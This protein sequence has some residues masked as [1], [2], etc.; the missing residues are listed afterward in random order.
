[1][2]GFAGNARAASNWETEGMRAVL[3]QLG[4]N[5]WCEWLPEDLRGKID[6]GSAE[7]APGRRPH[8][9]DGRGRTRCAPRLRA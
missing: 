7:P 5:M 2:A 6:L 3:L 8:E 9:D 1:M 4:H